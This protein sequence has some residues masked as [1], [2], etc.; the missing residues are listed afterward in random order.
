MKESLHHPVQEEH[1]S[2]SL[3]RP[4]QEESSM[5]KWNAPLPYAVPEERSPR[6][7]DGA[8][9]GSHSEELCASRDSISNQ[10]RTD[11]D[12]SLASNCRFTGE[13]QLG[14]SFNGEPAVERM[15]PAKHTAKHMDPG[16]RDKAGALKGML[17]DGEASKQNWQE[18]MKDSAPRRDS[19]RTRGVPKVAQD[20]LLNEASKS[21]TNETFNL[22]QLGDSL[23]SQLNSSGPHNGPVAGARFGS[24]SSSTCAP[25]LS[26][27][28]ES[29]HR[30]AQ[31]SRVEPESL[32]G[33][34]PTGAGANES[35]TTARNGQASFPGNHYGD[36]REG[37]S[38]GNLSSGTNSSADGPCT[39][40]EDDNPDDD[41]KGHKRCDDGCRLM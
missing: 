27:S 4:V 6:K 38:R 16:S 32:H 36:N 8:V 39:A 1:P 21:H 9:N 29:P 40:I 5:G 17:F 30:K 23:E 33:T 11:D 15:G 7:L 24:S 3:S 25:S 28:K 13:A 20:Q 41:L 14:S 31:H 10:T 22:D 35:M 26:G 34:L 12:L 37:T 18:V 2:A 19:P